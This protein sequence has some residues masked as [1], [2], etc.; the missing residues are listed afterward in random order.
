MSGT[1]LIVGTTPFVTQQRNQQTG[2]WLRTAAGQSCWTRS[3][4]ASLP[5]EVQG[6]GPTAPLLSSPALVLMPEASG[7]PSFQA[8]RL[9]ET[10][11]LFD[12]AGF[13]RLPMLGY[14][15]RVSSVSSDEIWL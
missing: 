9:T 8:V 5:A 14:I 7:S 4:V 10:H 11:G 3:L 15:Y 13:I 2:R 1:L 6:H 12:L